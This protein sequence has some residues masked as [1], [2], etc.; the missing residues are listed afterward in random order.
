MFAAKLWG[1]AEAIDEAAGYRLG[2]VE[3]ELRERAVPES[4]ERAG[5]DAFDRAWADGRVLS[6]EQA[7]ALALESSGAG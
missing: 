7:V 4:R 3:R 6:S 5:L 1:A 2:P